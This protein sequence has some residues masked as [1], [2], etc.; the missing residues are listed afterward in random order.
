VL[1]LRATTAGDVTQPGPPAPWAP[2]QVRAALHPR[3]ASAPPRWGGPQQGGSAAAALRVKPPAPPA[4]PSP[5]SCPLPRLPRPTC[6]PRQAYYPRYLFGEWEVASRFFSFRAPL[7]LRFV[8]PELRAAAQAAPEDGGPG[9]EYKFRARFY[10]T[11]PDT[12]EN[13]ARVNLG[14]GVRG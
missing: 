9:S 1:L 3:P 2:R 10:S 4:H 13:N 11:L 8:A 7:G 12:F 6:P 5:P 14:E